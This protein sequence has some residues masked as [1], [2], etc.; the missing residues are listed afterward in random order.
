MYMC[1]RGIKLGPDHPSSSPKKSWTA[2]EGDG[3]G[4]EGRSGVDFFL[5]IRALFFYR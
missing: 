1:V 3:E 4:K 2:Q 5:M